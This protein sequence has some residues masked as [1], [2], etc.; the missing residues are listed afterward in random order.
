[1]LQMAKPAQHGQG[2]RVLPGLLLQLTKSSN[3]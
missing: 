2:M 1:V 3:R